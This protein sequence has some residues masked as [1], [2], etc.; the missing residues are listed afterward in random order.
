MH[1][2]LQGKNSDFLSQ[3]NELV[4]SQVVSTLDWYQKNATW[5]RR[6]FRISGV[7]VIVLSVSIPLLASLSYQGKDLVLSIVASLIACFTGLNS[8][9][10]MA[11]SPDGQMLASGG[12]NHSMILWHVM[13]RQ[14]R[15]Q[16][17]TGHKEDVTSVAFSPAGQMLASGSWDNTVVLWEVATH[18]PGIHL[19]TRP[20][21]LVPSVTVNRAGEMFVAAGGHKTIILWDVQPHSPSKPLEERACSIANRNVTDTEWGKYLVGIPY[22]KTCPN[23]P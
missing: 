10:K 5:P 23:L 16:P 18:K 14:P 17:L 13:S 22:R 19:P 1:E 12:G 8:F 11:F 3:I 6:L 21:T 2:D 4:N 7:T 15:G 9:F 20:N